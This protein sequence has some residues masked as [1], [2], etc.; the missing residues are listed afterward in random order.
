MFTLVLGAF[1]GETVGQSITRNL[2]DGRQAFAQLI[3][4]PRGITTATKH[5]NILLYSSSFVIDLHGYMSSL[6][7]LYSSDDVLVN[8][9]DS[10]LLPYALL[11]SHTAWSHRA[12]MTAIIYPST[13][14]STPIP[15]SAR[16]LTLSN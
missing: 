6:D 10:F 14:S 9:F 11:K 7:W 4:G 5:L 3:G 8:S 15:V 13:S 2:A 1:G 16:P 12:H